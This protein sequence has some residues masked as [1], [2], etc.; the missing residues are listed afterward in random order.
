[1]FW[2]IGNFWSKPNF[3]FF[4]EPIFVGILQILTGSAEIRERGKVVVKYISR[5]VFWG[6]LKNA[7]KMYDFWKAG[8][9]LHFHSPVDLLEQW[10]SFLSVCHHQISS[11]RVWRR[12]EKLVIFMWRYLLLL[13]FLI[14]DTLYKIL[15]FFNLQLLARV[16]LLDF[17]RR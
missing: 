14:K 5:S 6:H 9:K 10:G 11:S 2:K 3:L 16:D 15:N 4:E 1:M 17:R 8:R 13:K 12:P 7:L